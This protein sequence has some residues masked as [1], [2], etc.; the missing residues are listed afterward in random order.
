MLAFEYYKRFD[1]M[2]TGP[3]KVK[4]GF[5][6]PLPRNQTLSELKE[7]LLI[8]PPAEMVDKLSVY[9]ESGIDEIHQTVPLSLLRH[10]CLS[11]VDDL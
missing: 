2:F 9:A 5:I 8:C 6:E 3:G 7:N 11:D 1:N 10:D 4:K